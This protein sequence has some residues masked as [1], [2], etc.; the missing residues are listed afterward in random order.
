M[1]KII[2]KPL[3]QSSQQFELFV[4]NLPKKPY[5]SNE[6]SNGLKIRNIQH[7]IQHRYIQPNHPNSKLWLLYDIDRPIGLESIEDLNLPQPT[8]FVQNPKNHH[9]HLFY[10][11]H[12]SVHMNRNSSMKAQRFAGVVDVSMSK[13]LDADAG[14][15]GLIAKNPMH[16][17]WRTYSTSL[18][19]DLQDF[20][21]FVDFE[22]YKDKRKSI[23]A[24]GLGRNVSLFD[25]LRRWAYRAI[26]Q[27]YPPFE[28]WHKA[29]FERAWGINTGFAAPLPV[30]EVKATAKSVAKY[31]HAKYTPSSFSALQAERGKRSGQAR[32]ALSVDKREQARELASQGLKVAEIAKLV[33]VHRDTVYSWLKVVG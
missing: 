24:V 15:V 5:C 8:F 32:L 31:V 6:L 12:K 4:A 22:P 13:A 23:E 33:S 9:A 29:C 1:R 10:G 20:A 30:S 19:Y 3:V 14:Y 16:E 17:H 21:E 2:P 27:G 28:Q 26:R 18:A 25:S 11:L 7:A